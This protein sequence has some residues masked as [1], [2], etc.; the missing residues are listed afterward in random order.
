MAMAFLRWAGRPMAWGRLIP[1]LLLPFMLREVM[2]GT[3][4]WSPTVVMNV[5]YALIATVVLAPLILHLIKRH[6]RGIR[7]VALAVGAFSIALAFRILDHEPI[8]AWMP[9]GSHWLWHS[10][11][12]LAVL[13]PGAG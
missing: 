8:M 5:E 9:M 6:W 10:F 2:T 11:G 12:G 13:W 7:L 1:L 4:G 3:M